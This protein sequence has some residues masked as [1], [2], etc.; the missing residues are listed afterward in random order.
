MNFVII[1]GPQASGK[2]TV[3]R[4]LES[5]TG[6]PLLHNHMTLEL[7]HPFF[8]FSDETFRLSK[9]F[10]EEMFK[11]LAAGNTKGVI[12]TMVWAFDMREDWEFIN[13]TKDIFESAGH[14][15]YFVE[16]EADTATRIFRNKTEERLIHKPTKRDLAASEKE[17]LESMEK[18]R[19]NS[20]AGEIS[21]RPYI[22]IN[23]ANKLPEQVA[24]M[25]CK[26]FNFQETLTDVDE[27][28]KA[29]NSLGG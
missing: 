24:E 1:F 18:H 25:I 16:L 20:N 23:N 12:F 29:G 19:L 22:R 8:G 7:L 10:R 2:M 14:N 4:A 17:L 9:L 13:D 6:F 28:V 11:S 21:H 27:K 26:E 5:R 3:G 15:V